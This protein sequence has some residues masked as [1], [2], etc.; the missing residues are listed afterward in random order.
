[1]AIVG[2]AGT[3]IGPLVGATLI[4]V[5]ENI[6]SAYTERWQMMLG[7]TFIVIMILA[8][9]GVAGKLRELFIRRNKPTTN[10]KR[11]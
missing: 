5:L 11:G 9:E 8:P 7:L 4:I 6:V 3:M 2:G 1:M 10:S